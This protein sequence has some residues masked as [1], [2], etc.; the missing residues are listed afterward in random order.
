MPTGGTGAGAW[1][2]DNVVCRRVPPAGSGLTTG[3]DGTLQVS[4]DTASGLAISG[5]GVVQV[6]MDPSKA[7][8][9]DAQGRLVVNIDSTDFQF[10]SNYLAMK[11][12]DLAKAANFDS[13]MF[14]L[15]PGT[16]VFTQ[17]AINA[18]MMTLGQWLRVGGG[19]DMPG[20]VQVCGS[21][22]VMV[23]WIGQ[24]GIYY[25]GGFKQLYVAYTGNDV[26]TAK[27]IADSSGNLSIKDAS[28]SIVRAGIGTI[29]IDPLGGFRYG[30]GNT[31]CDITPT[32]ISMQLGSPGLALNV[33]SYGGQINLIDSS[34][35][36]VVELSCGSTNFIR[37]NGEVRASS[38]K[39]GGMTVIDS[40]RNLV[41]VTLPT[42]NHTSFSAALNVSGMVTAQGFTAWGSAGLGS[43]GGGPHPRDVL[44]PGGGTMTLWFMGGLLYAET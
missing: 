34:G 10:V 30:S 1:L 42:H 41:S 22:G 35:I 9:F 7:M 28:I 17:K 19:S 29:T 2:I 24:N 15:A 38:L 36:G 12:I 31:Y 11:R 16:N 43:S 23:G 25:G 13:T 18:E 8:A 32:Q 39:I 5:S 33:T 3:S 14:Q 27:L 21:G 37:V 20:Q 40:S 4:V 26:S 6:K 44:V